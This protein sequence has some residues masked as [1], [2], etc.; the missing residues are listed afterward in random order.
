[1]II[2]FKSMADKIIL[3]CVNNFV[4]FHS[5]NNKGRILNINRFNR[6]NSIFYAVL[7]FKIKSSYLV[8][9]GG[10]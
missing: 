7:L 2:L 10:L 9:I 3:G 6:N 1:M 8:I 4:Y 5:L